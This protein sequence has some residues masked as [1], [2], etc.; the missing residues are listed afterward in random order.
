MLQ[1]SLEAWL[2]IHK[3]TALSLCTGKTQAMP[4]LEIIIPE[5]LAAQITIP[6]GQLTEREE[7]DD[8]HKKPSLGIPLLQP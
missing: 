1:A 4:S 5:S 6:W 3:V 8:S 2:P 7:A